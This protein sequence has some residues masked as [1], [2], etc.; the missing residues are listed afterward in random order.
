ME[1]T[2]APLVSPGRCSPLQRPLTDSIQ[3]FQM[4]TRAK[5]SSITCSTRSRQ[6]G[7]YLRQRAQRAS[8]ISV[9]SVTSPAVPYYHCAL[10]LRLI[11]GLDHP[12]VSTA[13]RQTCG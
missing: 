8:R 3:I 6:S 1:S 2:Y 11:D 9:S 7:L 13:V 5:L 4:A 10:V 12:L